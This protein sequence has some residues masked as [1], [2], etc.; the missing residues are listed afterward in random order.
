MKSMLLTLTALLAFGAH[1]VA[2]AAARPSA[3]A[4]AGQPSATMSGTLTSNAGKFFLTDDATRTTVEVR[5]EGLAKHLGQKVSLTGELTA[6]TAGSPEVLTISSIS[7]TAAVGGK[8]AAAGLKAG[9][10]KAA[11]VGV[12]GAGTAATVGT[13]YATD[14]IGGQETSVSRQ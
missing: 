4:Q 6:G 9:V 3:S 14:V 8:A 12:A 7:R 2:T 1:S 5:G 13:L 11:V 10:S